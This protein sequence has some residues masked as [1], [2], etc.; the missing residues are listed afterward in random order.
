[1]L[2]PFMFRSDCIPAGATALRDFRAPCLLAEKRDRLPTRR[3]PL[4]AAAHVVQQ[5]D[6]LA[7]RTC[8]ETRRRVR[9]LGNAGSDLPGTRSATGTYRCFFS[10]RI[11]DLC[12]RHVIVESLPDDGHCQLL[13]V[14]PSTALSA[15]RSITV[16]AKETNRRQDVWEQANNTQGV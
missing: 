15:W 12:S 4:F 9:H 7:A 11:R 14:V 3:R 5:R 10:S 2:R 8:E 16:A 6:P 13:S 1:M